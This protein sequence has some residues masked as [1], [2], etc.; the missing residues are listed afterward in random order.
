MKTQFK[1]LTLAIAALNLVQAS[2]QSDDLGLLAER[3]AKRNFTQ[4]V[5]CNQLET[6]EAP[7][8]LGYF[9]SLWGSLS[10]VAKVAYKY[11]GPIAIYNALTA[12]PNVEE[13]VAAVLTD[14]EV[15]AQQIFDQKV[16]EGKIVPKTKKQMKAHKAAKANLA[17]EQKDQ[18]K[19]LIKLRAERNKEHVKKVEAQRKQSEA[20]VREAIRRDTA[21]REARAEN[22]GMDIEPT[23]QQ[24]FI[25]AQKDQKALI[26]RWF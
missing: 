10:S 17:K 15:F 6:V 22:S 21:Y 4:G 14:S 8:R 1:I 24:R 16:K 19:R 18:K 11:A 7:S 25:K 20:A 26:D 13:N 23:A 5:Q 2:D 12:A 3:S 9:G